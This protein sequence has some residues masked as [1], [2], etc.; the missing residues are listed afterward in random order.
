MALNASSISLS[1]ALSNVVVLYEQSQSKLKDLQAKLEIAQIYAKNYYGSKVATANSLKQLKDVQYALALDILKLSAL[2]WQETDF[3]KNGIATAATKNIHRDALNKITAERD[4]LQAKIN[5]NVPALNAAERY[6]IEWSQKYAD[7]VQVVQN[8]LIDINKTNADIAKFL[9]SITS[10]FTY[11]NTNGITKSIYTQFDTLS[12]TFIKNEPRILFVAEYFDTS[13]KSLGSLLVWEKYPNATHYEVF[14]K[15]LFLENAK[16]ERVLF[17]DVESL[18]KET[19]YYISYLNNALNLN[20]SVDNSYVIFDP[21]VKEDRIYEYK[22]KA[23]LVPNAITEI[24]FNAIVDGKNLGLSINPPMIPSSVFHIGLTTYGNAK[25]AW[26]IA[27]LNDKLSFFGYSGRRDLSP[28]G[29]VLA[30]T[31]KILAAKNPDT[32]L[33]IIKDSYSLFGEKNTLLY[34][35]DILGGLNSDFKDS[36][37]RIYFRK[38]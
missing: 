22:I 36:F 27:L 30:Q 29:G 4:A 21:L 32:I 11:G 13:Q 5:Q 26:I 20:L 2:I 17:L 31:E 37:R 12:R 10:T 16:F 35:L 19:A 23:S 8:I 3:L 9:S 15:N 24:D 34:I 14:K 6:S 33:S 18:K 38:F 28:A 1:P 25:M 7:Q